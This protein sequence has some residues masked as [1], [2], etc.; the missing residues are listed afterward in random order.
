M[1]LEALF[2]GE[3]YPAET[4]RPRDRRYDEATQ[5]VSDSMHYFEQTLSEGDYERLKTMSDD[6]NDAQARENEEH[7]MSGFVMGMRLMQEIYQ[8]PVI[9]KKD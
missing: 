8:Y 7:F 6:L 5:S 1:V 4:V 2:N 9:P 3:I